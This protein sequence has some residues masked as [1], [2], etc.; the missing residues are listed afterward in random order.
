MSPIPTASASALLLALVLPLAAYGV[1]P[2]EVFQQARPSVPVLESLAKDGEVLN[3]ASAIALGG[4]R[5]VGMC[6][7]LDGGDAIR[8]RL[9]DRGFAATVIARD[10]AR[11]L[12]LLSAPEASALPALPLAPQDALPPVGARVFA[13]S[14]ALGFGIGLSDGVISGIRR[15]DD[16]TFLQFSAPVSPGSEGGALVDEAGRLLGIIDYRQRDGQNVNFAAPAAWIAQIEQRQDKDRQ[17]QAFRDGA[18]RLARAD[19]RAGLAKLATEWTTKYPDDAD[20]WIWLAVAEQVRGDLGAEERAWRRA[21]TLTPAAIN[22]GIGLAG[23]LV[24]QQ[25]FAE[26]RDV[27]QS[28]LR[29][30]QENAAVWAVLGQAHHGAGAIAEAEQAYRKALSIDPWQAAAHQGVI[31]LAEQRGDRAA[32]IS[33]WGELVR[34]YPDRPLY[35][36]RLI[37]NL[38]YAGQTARAYRLL[39][40][41]P[42]DLAESGDALF[43]KGATSAQLERPQEA[44]AFF[45][46]SLSRS[47]ANPAR[48]WTQLGKAY[49]TVERFP[50]AI[51]ALREAVRLT[52]SSLEARYW[53][54]VVLKDGGHVGEAIE[55][56]RKLV[57]E[58]SDNAQVWRQLGFAT[59]MAGSIA[60][61]VSPLERSLALDPAQP[62][63]WRALA[64][65]YHASGRQEDVLRAYE[66]LR[67]LDATM[68]EQTYRSLIQRQ[69]GGQ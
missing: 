13:V 44:I 48:V 24:R 55:L 16:D 66:K 43:L 25:R 35:R 69:E 30:T 37:E 34:L 38:L 2:A 60:E 52:P 8:I 46:Q 45:R 50:E 32:A 5:F 22:V 19:D 36:W 49:F 33:G 59:M 14:N 68:A 12:C 63:V 9:D 67:G 27:A 65:A 20:G 23:S 61:S 58:V 1:T 17:R 10:T 6:S 57:A 53:L 15:Y 47:P 31:W 21:Q 56:D 62:R 42:E 54:A 26:A 3:Y 64:T 51:A 41:L 39:A 18:P 28:L 11:N 4:G 29:H 7:P 40:S